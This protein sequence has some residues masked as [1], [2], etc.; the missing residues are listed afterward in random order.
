MGREEGP[1]IDEINAARTEQIKREAKVFVGR[2]PRCIDDRVRWQG[3]LNLE[4]VVSR[5][6]FNGPQFLGG[7]LGIFALLVEARARMNENNGEI[8]FEEIWGETVRMHDE[9]GLIIGVHM[10]DHHGEIKGEDIEARL[11]KVKRG[12][13]GEVSVIPGCGFAGLLSREDNPLGLS[14]KAHDFFRKNPNVVDEMV[15]QGAKLSILTGDHAPKKHAHAVENMDSKTTVNTE[16][17][18]G[19]GVQTYNHDTGKLQ[20][21]LGQDEIA[22][23][24]FEI[25]QDWLRKT[26]Q[27]LAGMDPVKMVV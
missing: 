4:N 23:L 11:V 22:T 7:S 12:K 20:E 26:T 21:V 2:I 18:I 6:E 1:S 8:N 3:E 16:K 14:D 27:I 9:Q 25:N 19:L 24:M 15:R 13:L 10:D 17:A 5:E